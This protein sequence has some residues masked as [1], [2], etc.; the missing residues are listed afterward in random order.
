M[1][2]GLRS[3][4]AV[5]AGYL[6][7]VVGVVAIDAACSFLGPGLLTWINLVTAA[8]CGTLGGWA[9]ARLASRAKAGHAWTLAGF[10]LLMGLLYAL[11]DTGQP[12]WYRVALPVLG[13]TGIVIGGRLGS[14]KGSR[15]A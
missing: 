10:S 9:T 1:K 13:A 5:I 12:G 4:G 8:P 2:E 7:M 14:Q 6:A 11:Q 15:P 3:I